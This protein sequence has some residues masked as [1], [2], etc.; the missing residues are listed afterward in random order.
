LVVPEIVVFPAEID[1]SNAALFGVE[2]LAA[3]RFGVA[4]VIAVMTETA[5]CDSSDIRHLLIANQRAKRSL[6]QPLHWSRK[7]EPPWDRRS[8]GHQIL[9]MR[10]HLAAFNDRFEGWSG[11]YLVGSKARV[12][13]KG[14]I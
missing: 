6:A 13:K 5:F 7:P 14:L 4:V 3:F 2:L 10:V 11:P 1:I 9:V 12:L 8:R